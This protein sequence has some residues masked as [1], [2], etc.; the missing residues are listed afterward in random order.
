MKYSSVLTALLGL[1][2]FAGSVQSQCA[3]ADIGDFPFGY[4]LGGQEDPEDEYTDCGVEGAEVSLKISTFFTSFTTITTTT[5][6]DPIVYFN[7]VFVSF[8][9]QGVACKNIVKIKQLQTRCSTLSGLFDMVFTIV[10]QYFAGLEI[11]DDITDI[12]DVFTSGTNSCKT[13]GKRFGKFFKHIL[14]GQVE[15]TVYYK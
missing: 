3:F 5:W 12:I 14:N 6:T 15:G 10:F 4:G 8:S 7:Q 13:I 11:F 1:V 2:L 9:N